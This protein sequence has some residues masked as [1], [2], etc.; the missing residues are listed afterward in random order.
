MIWI[1]ADA[2]SDT[3]TGHVMRCLSLAAELKKLGAELCFLLADDRPVP[4]LLKAGQKYRILDSD[5]R[6][7]EKETDGLDRL[8]REEGGSFF[9]ADSYYVTAGYFRQVRKHMPAGYMDDRGVRG[10]PLD[11]LINYNIF[12]EAGL[13]GELPQETRLLLGPRYA[14][15]REEFRGREYRVR[16]RAS[17]VLVTTG[18]SDR[19]NLAGRF[20]REALAGNG[21]AGLEYIVIS[22]A[23]NVHLPELREL[24][25]ENSNVEVLCGVG[26]MA[27][28]MLKCDIAVTAGGSTMYELSAIGVPILCFSFV[29]NQEGIVNGFRERDLVYYGGNFLLK[30][31]AMVKETAEKLGELAADVDA[32]RRYSHRQRQVADGLGALRLAEEILRF[33]GAHPFCPETV[34][35]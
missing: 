4:L 19:Y 28:L 3:G 13:Y 8:F 2:N 14:P 6:E 25:R 29:D 5:Y 17:R 21:T 31:E 7:M 24:E 20:L 23:Y 1:R 11:M 30:G 32:R 22:G 16:D 9:L 33:C 15:L 26:N 10:L 12:A 27:E 18:G 35:K 34:G